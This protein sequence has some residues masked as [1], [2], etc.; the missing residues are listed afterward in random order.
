M[1][2]QLTR[3]TLGIETESGVAGNCLGAE[4]GRAI[5]SRSGDGKSR[6]R[7]GWLKVPFFGSSQKLRLGKTSR[8]L[9][10]GAQ[11]MSKISERRRHCTAKARAPTS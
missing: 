1:A 10:N 5:P 4:G 2:I 6:D 3:V 9:I 7:R 11:G 8:N